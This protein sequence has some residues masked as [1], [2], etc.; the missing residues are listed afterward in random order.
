[1]VPGPRIRTLRA[2]M[3]LDPW[4]IW[5]IKIPWLVIGDRARGTVDVHNVGHSAVQ[6]WGE[7]DNSW[8][9]GGGAGQKRIDRS[10]LPIAR[11]RSYE[12]IDKASWP[13]DVVTVRSVIIYP[14]HDEQTTTQIVLSRRVLV[15][16]RWV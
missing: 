5:G 15:V 6:F 9:P 16:S 3:A 4:L 14:P 1:N 8:W 7:V 13:I 11:S 10:L 2:E 12:I